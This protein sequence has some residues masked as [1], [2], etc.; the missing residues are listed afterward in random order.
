MYIRSDGSALVC[1]PDDFW[2]AW[3]LSLGTW[4]LL[5]N[6]VC[7]VAVCS[8]EHLLVLWPLRGGS[9]NEIPDMRYFSALYWVVVFIGKQKLQWAH[10][11]QSKIL[12]YWTSSCML[13]VKALQ[14]LLGAKILM[15]LG[16]SCSLLCRFQWDLTTNN[17]WSY[18]S[19]RTGFPLNKYLLCHP[20]L[21]TFTMCET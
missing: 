13:R 4:W 21:H 20:I 12:S 2:L 19:Y 14:T 3:Q 8:R 1:L 7:T 15:C 9:C 10:K 18:S 6:P 5:N 17:A 11:E 16:P